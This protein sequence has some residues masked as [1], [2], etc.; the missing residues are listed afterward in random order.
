MDPFL[1]YMLAINAVAFLAFSIDFFPVAGGAVGMLFALF[2]FGRT[3]RGH[4]INKDNV[5]WWFLAIVC[6]FVWGF[7][8]IARYGLVTLDTSISGKFWEPTWL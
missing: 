7:I 3:G 2:V 4:R 8:V 5:A 1:L 6:L